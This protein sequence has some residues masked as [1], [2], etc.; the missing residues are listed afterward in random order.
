[1]SKISRRHFFEHSLMTAATGMAGME[2]I[3][4]AD[5]ASGSRRRIDPND[6]IHIAVIGLNG[7]GMNH[8]EDY[9]AR[10]D[11]EVVAL[12]DPDMNVLDRAVASIEK[13]NNRLQDGAKTIPKK[14]QDIR[15][16]LEM[17]G[18]DAVSI[19]TP[20]HWH[21]LAAIWALQS[22][23]DVYVEKPVSH[24]VI[25]GRRLSEVAHKTGRI[26]QA[27]TQ[28]R[29]HKACI[30]A[31]EYIHSG[32]IG[33]VTVSRGLCYKSRKSIGKV[34][35]DQ[36]VPTGV[37]YDLWLGPAPMKPIHRKQFHYDWHWFWDYGNGDL[38]NQGI[39]QMDIARWALGKNTLPNA[40]MSI[41]GRFGYEDDGETPNTE[42]SFFD[43]GDEHL[44]FE[45]RGLKTSGYKGVSIGNIVHGKDGYVVISSDY[46]KAMAFDNDDKKVMDFTGGGNHFGNFLSAVRSRKTSEL[47]APVLEGH[48]SSALCHLGNISYRMGSLVPFNPKTKAFGDDKEAY[49]TIGRFEQHLIDNDVKLEAMQYRLGPHLMI[50]PKRET[51]RNNHEANNYLTREYRQ[52]FAVPEKA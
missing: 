10:N 52:G 14:V 32:K 4:N 3:A 39:H 44:I 1:M 5:A 33:K 43:Y 46:G 8:L 37:D 23:K 7:R 9:I 22:G 30:D 29:S 40:V 36:A 28:S 18:I 19:A 17:K 24:N 25:E 15:K 6:K 47:N 50:D 45:V 20:N 21:S 11:V 2:A 13:R 41:G 38:G 27:G 16:L 35:G 49:E 26:C 12:C 48:L 42:L 31:I 51:F 34:A